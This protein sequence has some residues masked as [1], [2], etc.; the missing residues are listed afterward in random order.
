MKR[1]VC[2]TLAVLA[3]VA[4]A[5]AQ[6]GTTSGSGFQLSTP[7]SQRKA[8]ASPKTAEEGAAYQTIVSNP[9]LAAAE[10]AA[11][12]F[13]A[14]YPQTELGGAIYWNLAY[15]YQQSNNADKTVE[16][17]RK[18][19]KFDP[20]QPMALVTVA[21]VLAER[22]K[23]TD[24]DRDQ[25]LGEAV[26]HAQHAIA[27]MDNWLKTAAGITDEQAAA[28]KPFL[29][30][31]AHESLGVVEDKRKN[32]AEAEKHYRTS[33]EM[34]TAHPEAL[35]WLRLALALDAQKKYAEALTAC[36]RAVELSAATPG[37]VADWA[38]Q[39]QARLA[40]LTG[41][42]APPPAPAPAPAPATPPKS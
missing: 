2:T 31:R 6:T 28:I 37:I 42:A 27:S 7:T 14:K 16:M 18:V 5:A 12:D 10:A 38:K 24:L 20:D 26:Q 4:M 32:P 1:I 8:M 29:A 11:K 34:N 9:D 33:A 40:K 23:E 17:G 13:E 25:R 36:N 30:A 35:T 3:A 19:L 41:T 15:R 22:T 21:G 39:E